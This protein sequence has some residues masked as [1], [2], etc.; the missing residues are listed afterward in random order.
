MG[1]M[2]G[3]EKYG[4]AATDAVPMIKRDQGPVMS[5]ESKIRQLA[6]DENKPKTTTPGLVEGWK[7]L[8]STPDTELS[9]ERS[10]A[11]LAELRLQSGKV[12]SGDLIGDKFEE[13]ARE[14]LSAGVDKDLVKSIQD[15]VVL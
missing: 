10:R 5:A 3:S 13:F 14:A 9:P 2:G 1:E 6:R 4:M 12:A 15:Q 7:I 8:D 11:Y